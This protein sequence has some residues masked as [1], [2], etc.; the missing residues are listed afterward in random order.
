[1]SVSCAGSGRFN[2]CPHFCPYF[3]VISYLLVCHPKHRTPSEVLLYVPRCREYPTVENFLFPRCRVRDPGSPPVQRVFFDFVSFPRPRFAYIDV[4]F[5]RQSSRSPAWRIC[6]HLVAE[7]PKDPIYGKRRQQF[8]TVHRSRRK[9]DCE[10]QGLVM[11]TS[12]HKRVHCQC[13]ARPHH[14]AARWPWI[15]LR[16]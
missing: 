16:A 14:S 9:A 15:R 6:V 5:V 12:P 3:G 8:V 1:V 4:A 11:V 2:S 10:L 13:E 7:L